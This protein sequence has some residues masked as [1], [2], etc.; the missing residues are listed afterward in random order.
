M[1]YLPH[2][3][4]LALTGCSSLLVG[5]ESTDGIKSLADR[6]LHG[7]GDDF[8]FSLTSQ[9]ELWSRWNVPE[10]DEY[11]VKACDGGKICIEGSTL[12]ALARG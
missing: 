11:T 7:H 5:A 4:V 3:C 1:V 10:N 2:F 8:K 12:S 9:H 6:M